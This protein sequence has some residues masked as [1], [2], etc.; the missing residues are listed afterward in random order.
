MIK[1]VCQAAAEFAILG[2]RENA[3]L[4]GPVMT[5]IM[6]RSFNIPPTHTATFSRFLA[7]R[8]AGIQSA[9]RVGRAEEVAAAAVFLAG[10]GPRWIHGVA[11]PVEG[12]V[13]ILE[14][15]NRLG[16]RQS[17]EM[18]DSA[19]LVRFLLQI[20]SGSS[21]IAAISCGP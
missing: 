21:A 12:K 13:I 19:G 7:E 20:V 18:L 10:D 14:P 2:I 6:A 11:L 15:N 3:I 9:R 8:T 1:I 17:Y 4:P 16:G 5:P